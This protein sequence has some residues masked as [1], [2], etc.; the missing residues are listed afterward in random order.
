MQLKTEYQKPELLVEE[1]FASL[2]SKGLVSSLTNTIFVNPIKIDGASDFQEREFIE[3]CIR[4]NGQNPFTRAPMTLEELAH[5]KDNEGILKDIQN[6]TREF[7]EA[8][9]LHPDLEQIKKSLS[10]YFYE[11][12]SITLSNESKQPSNDLIAMRAA[13]NSPAVFQQRRFFFEQYR[14]A[15]QGELLQLLG[16]HINIRRIASAE[17]NRIS[18]DRDPSPDRNAL[19]ER[20]RHEAENLIFNE[21]PISS[22]FAR[23]IDYALLYILGRTGTLLNSLLNEG[24]LQPPVEEH[25][26]AIIDRVVRRVN[27]E[28][29]SNQAGYSLNF[30]S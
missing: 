16:D 25:I 14:S 22:A 24:D 11:K 5:I 1:F 10:T 29:E 17:V 6:L 27:S 9:A 23:E 30:T 3:N 19:W 2:N 26:R 13:N 18:R 28:E 8:Q 7:L 12:S 21:Q 4:S 20:V 15:T